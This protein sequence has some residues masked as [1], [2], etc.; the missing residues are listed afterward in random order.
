MNE[1]IQ[2][3]V[4]ALKIQMDS[5][6]QSLDEFKLHEHTGFD[7]S[8]LQ[9]AYTVNLPSTAIVYTDASIGGDKITLF[10]LTTTQ[11]FTM[12]NPTNV[13]DGKRIIYKIKQ[14]GTGSRIITWGSAFRNVVSSSTNNY[15]VFTSSGTWT[16]PTGLTGNELVIVQLWGGGGAGGGANGANFGGGGGGGGAFVETRFRASDLS[17]TVTVTVGTGGG[18]TTSDGNAG[19]NSTFGAYVTAYAGGGGAHNQGD[20]SGGAGGGGGAMS[21][22]TS[23]TGNNGGGGGNP[24]G[25]APGSPGAGASN[26]GWGGGGGGSIGSGQGSVGGDSGSGGGGGGSAGGGAVT[27]GN[28]GNSVY[29]GAGGGGGGVTGGAGGTSLIYGGNGGSGSSG[30]GVGTAG[31]APGGGGG[32]AFRSSAGTSNGGNGA[33]GECRVFV[34]DSPVASTSSL[35]LTTTANAVDYFEFIY[36]ASISKWN[37][38][39]TSSGFA[40]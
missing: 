38:I 6:S 8:L 4:D 13:V 19:V 32:G 10:A 33:R 30:T 39:S 31:V 40:S 36:D 37:L 18:G 1:E 26:A 29:G 24:A 11:N 25:G 23:V 35:V 16:K 2:K 17:A 7:A 27:G 22:G 34:I 28:G 12:A 9:S 20:P 3:E 15:Q 14:D 5:L 21:A